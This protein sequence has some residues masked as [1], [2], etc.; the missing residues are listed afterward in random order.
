[1][2]DENRDKREVATTS[3]SWKLVAGGAILAVAT[4]AGFILFRGAA[5]QTKQQLAEE[6]ARL[7][8][9][10][11]DLGARCFELEQQVAGLQAQTSML[12]ASESRLRTM[13]EF[14]KHHY[15]RFAI[16]YAMRRRDPP[17]GYLPSDDVSKRMGGNI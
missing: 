2:P 13:Y 14:A 10:A 15:V 6:C 11:G 17:D 4:A 5:E 8:R 7:Q 9:R 16:F 12:R 3:F 1:M